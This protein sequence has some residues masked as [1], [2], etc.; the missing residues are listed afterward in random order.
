MRQA[1]YYVPDL[2]FAPRIADAL[3]HLNFE[4]RE[5]APTDEVAGAD[6]LIVQLDGPRE[7]WLAL[8]AAARAAAVPVLAFGRHTD[9]ETLRAARQAGA[10]KVVPNS[11]LVAELPELVAALLN[12]NP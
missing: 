4:S 6:L 7:R 8:I 12:P 5:V 3:K 11:Q 9:A 10:D 2:F 1:L